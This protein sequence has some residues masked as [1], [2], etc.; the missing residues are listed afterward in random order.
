MI[1][2]AILSALIYSAIYLDE[3]NE[4]IARVEVACMMVDNVVKRECKPFKITYEVDK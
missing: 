2:Y 3:V 1:T 4:P